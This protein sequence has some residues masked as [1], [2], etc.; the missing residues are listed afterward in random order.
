MPGG[1]P[2][3]IQSYTKYREQCRRP[4]IPAVEDLSEPTESPGLQ[5]EDH[6]LT[7][8]P[9]SG[10]G[11]GERSHLKTISGHSHTRTM[12]QSP[13]AAVVVI[14]FLLA[15]A[16]RWRYRDKP[17]PSDEDCDL[18]KHQKA[19]SDQRPAAARID[20]KDPKREA[21]GTAFKPTSD[22]TS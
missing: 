4:R 19:S 11:P 17:R 3:V 22:P 2:V 8:T 15:L 18:P 16:Y 10:T 1:P 20:V 14:L 13:S 9:A 5:I 7:Q 6:S 21:S 12:E